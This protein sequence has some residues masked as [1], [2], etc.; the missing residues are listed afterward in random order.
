[1]K[2]LV[3]VML[4]FENAGCTILFETYRQLSMQPSQIVRQLMSEKIN[5]TWQ[6]AAIQMG[7]LE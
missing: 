4:D 3:S 2:D 6:H 7:W 1:M 5:K